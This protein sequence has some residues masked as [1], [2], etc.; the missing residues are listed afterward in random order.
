[1][2]TFQE[3]LGREQKDLL[4]VF[5]SDE[6]AGLEVKH[7]NAAINDP[8]EFCGERTDPCEGPELFVTGS[9]ALV[10]YQCGEER[11]LDLMRQLRGLQEQFSE[12][13]L[14]VRGAEPARQST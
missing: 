7:N 1:M 9:W 11:A 5:A 4:P 13:M 8:C 10:C 12:W 6:I 3:W 2:N 14:P